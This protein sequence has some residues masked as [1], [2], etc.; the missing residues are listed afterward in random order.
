M[1]GQLFTK[2]FLI[3]LV[4][5][6]MKVPSTEIP[7]CVHTPR[8]KILT[9]PSFDKEMGQP[10]PSYIGTFITRGNAKWCSHFEKAAG[11]FP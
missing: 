9:V 1:H 7:V 10:E 3:S 2:R 11:C 4:A 5:R 8:F 6:K